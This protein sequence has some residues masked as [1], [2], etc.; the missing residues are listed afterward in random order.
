MVFNALVL[1]GTK[2]ERPELLHWNTE[3]HL[4]LLLEGVRAIK[5]MATDWPYTLNALL[6]SP[7]IKLLFAKWPLVKMSKVPTLEE[8]RAWAAEYMSSQSFI[9][10]SGR[11]HLFGANHPVR[12]ELNALFGEKGA[13]L[14][15]MVT[16]YDIKF[17]VD[18]KRLWWQ[19]DGMVTGLAGFSLALRFGDL[20]GA[21]QDWT[22]ASES[23]Q[24]IMRAIQNGIIDYNTYAME[25]RVLRTART[26]V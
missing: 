13:R 2:L 25:F 11:F 21:K 10:G 16:T 9:E 6:K 23:C 12:A 24:A 4:D 20:D 14:R 19:F 8:K 26:V 15:N 3:E 1:T 7:A 5:S 18:V 22:I 17:G